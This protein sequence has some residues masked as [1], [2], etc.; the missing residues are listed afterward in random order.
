MDRSQLLFDQLALP[1]LCTVSEAVD[2]LAQASDPE[3][4][5]AIFTR[6]E[7]VEF[8]L[9]LVGYVPAAPLFRQRLLEPS[10]GTGDFLLPAVRRLL[11]SC[12]VARRADLPVPDLDGCIRAVELHADSFDLTRDGLLAQLRDAGFTSTQA[13]RLADRWLVQGDFLLTQFSHRFDVVVGNPPYVRQELIPA[14]LL[15]EYRRRYATLFDRADLYI[16]FIERSLQLL[17][18]AG[19]LSFICADRWMKNRYGGP[20]RALIAREFHLQC[21]VDM[22]DTPAFQS[23]VIAYPAITLIARAKR[24]PTMVAARPS[25]EKG[26]LQSIVPAL[27]GETSKLPASVHRLDDVTQGDAPWVLQASGTTDLV[28]RIEHTF[29][30]L[31]DAGCKVGIGVATGADSAY[32]GRYDE[33]DVEP[34]RKL[35]LVMTRDLTSGHVKWR[36]H[37]VINP[38]TDEGPLVDLAR[39]PKLHAH[40]D[41]HRAAIQKRHV[42]QRDPRRWY[43]TIDRITPALACRPKLLIP[44][45]KGSAQVVYEDGRLYP[46]HNLYYVVSECWDLRALQAVLLSALSRVFIA[47]YSTKMRGGFLRFQAQYLRR[48]RLPMWDDVPQALRERLA[49]AACALDLQACDEA[50]FD[51]YGLDARDRVLLERSV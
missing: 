40:L 7:V 16:P 18:E 1:G 10:F 26:H 17:D 4:R 15:A 9:D 45:I 48:L 33:L 12:E 32:I 41:R 43:R 24:G 47:T 20:L 37:G 14:A 51:L 46:H 42:A 44:D 49:Q 25:I 27:R 6:P 11:A 2:A 50:T 29:P 28:R 34:D 39:F 22:V 21:Y 30:L 19:A 8:I 38:F 31:E 36:G 5:G 23:E 3:Q 13:M 35:P